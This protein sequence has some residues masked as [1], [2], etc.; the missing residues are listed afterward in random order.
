MSL[1]SQL[2]GGPVE[3]W[4]AENLPGTSTLVAAVAKAAGCRAP[5]RPTG[6]VDLAHWAAVGGAFGQRLAFLVEP[7]P[8]YYALY[9]LVR[10]GLGGRRWANEQAAE[11]STHAH[12]PGTDRARA[13]ELRPTP[14]GWH[15]LGPAAGP[16][17]P[18]TPHEPVLADF[19]ARLRDYLARHAATG[20]IGP[21]GVEA[22]LARACWILAGWEDAYRG[23]ELPAE[24]HRLHTRASGCTVDDLRGLAAAHVVD[25][26][27]ALA[28]LAHTSGAIRELHQLAGNPPAGR[29][30][31][32]AAPVLVHHWADAD[33]LVGDTLLDVKTVIRLDNADR[34]ARWL[35]QLLGYAWLDEADKYKIHAVGLYLARHGVILRWDVDTFAEHLTGGQVRRARRAFRTLCAKAVAVESR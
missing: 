10:A 2:H 29:P 13:L 16:G 19:L 33:L 14:A 31:G 25:E 21:P 34:T 1:T 12:L 18:P 3:K 9:G 6:Q 5:V 35:W 26:L 30:L 11:W 23:G 20:H 7:A 8:P 15:D 22:G 17:T 4:C 28:H 32:T 24:L 27:A